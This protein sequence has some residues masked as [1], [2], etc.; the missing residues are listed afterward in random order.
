M[1]YL[2]LVVLLGMLAW[3]VKEG[4]EMIDDRLKS[5]LETLEKNNENDDK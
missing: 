2:I 4:F 3:N 5:I 1:G